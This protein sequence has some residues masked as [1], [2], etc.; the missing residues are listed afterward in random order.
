[1]LAKEI[2]CSRS[3]LYFS[4]RKPVRCN[5]KSSDSSRGFWEYK[6]SQGKPSIDCLVILLIS[7]LCGLSY[8]SLPLCEPT[9]R[10]PPAFRNL[11]TIPDISRRLTSPVQSSLSTNMLIPISHKPS[12]LIS[13][14]KPSPWLVSLWYDHRTWNTIDYTSRLDKI[15]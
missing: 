13:P 8:F 14:F 10:P 3:H 4:I 7:V 1:M 15:L 12:G 2:L 9:D 6:E 5:V 11:K